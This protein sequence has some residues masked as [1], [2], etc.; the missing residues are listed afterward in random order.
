MAGLLL[1][2]THWT[3]YKVYLFKSG[4]V[5]IGRKKGKTQQ[6]AAGQSQTQAAALW[7]CG[8]WSPTHPLS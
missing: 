2:Y 4:A 7:S 3:V 1:V 8:I 6:M 5:K